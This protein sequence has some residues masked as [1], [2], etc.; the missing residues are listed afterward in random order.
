MPPSLERQELTG[1]G[2]G[3]SEKPEV[4]PY[5]SELGNVDSKVALALEGKLDDEETSVPPAEGQVGVQHS[6]NAWRQESDDIL[7]N[8]GDGED[9]VRS[10]DAATSQLEDAE[11]SP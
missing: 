3:D 5:G 11:V 1:S 2:G 7:G 6:E 10:E 8:T 9:A 4:S